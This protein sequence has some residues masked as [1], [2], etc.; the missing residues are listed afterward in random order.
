MHFTFRTA[1]DRLSHRLHDKVLAGAVK[2]SSVMMLI[3]AAGLVFADQQQAAHADSVAARFSGAYAGLN[4]GVA[5]GSSRFV[6]APNCVATG[7]VFCAPTPTNALANGVLVAQA[8]TGLMHPTGFTGGLQAGYNWQAGALVY[9]GEVGFGALSLQRTAGASGGYRFFA[10]A[11]AFSLSNSID[12]DWL[13]TLRGR[14]GVTVTP[15]LLLYAAGGL[16]LTDINFTSIYL[17]NGGR[18]GTGRISDRRAGW[19]YGGG[20]QWALN[21]NWSVRAEY[22]YADFGSVSLPVVV[23]QPTVG[24]QTMRVEAELWTH[25][26]RFGVD[27]R[28]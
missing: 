16:A 17:D 12:T 27:Y 28:F 10:G 6:T 24:T 26:V 23:S 1:P 25:I 15:D 8:G 9:G 20:A 4:A 18:T 14:I 22:L 5:T 19:T 13:A 2:F 21:R 7:A 3:S 11:S